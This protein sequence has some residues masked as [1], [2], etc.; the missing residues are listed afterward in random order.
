VL[1]ASSDPKATS[2]DIDEYEN[3]LSVINWRASHSFPLN[4]FK[5]GL[6]SRTGKVDSK[7]LVAQRIKR[8]SS[9]QQKLDRFSGMKLSRM[10]DIAGCRS[11]VSSVGQ[12]DQIASLYKKKKGIKHE[13]SPRG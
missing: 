10:Q 13:L 2:F 9:I 5:I 4:T 8:L 1:V 6:L 7:G 11:I 3:A 12:V